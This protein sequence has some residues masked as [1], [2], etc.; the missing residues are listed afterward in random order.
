MIYQD[1]ECNPFRVPLSLVARFAWFNTGSYDSRIYAYE[2]DLSAGFS[3]APLYMSG[4]RTYFLIRYDIGRNLSC[5]LRISQINYAGK[6]SISSGPNKLEGSA[7]SEIKL[8]I[9]ARF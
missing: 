4:Y 1:V 6:E 7:R 5:R 2:Q 8:Q 3:F 9:T